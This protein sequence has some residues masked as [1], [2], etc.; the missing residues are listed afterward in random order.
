MD[1]RI[2]NVNGAGSEMLLE[3]LELAFKQ[4]GKNTKCKAWAI[5]KNHGLIL[6]WYKS[7]RPSECAFPSA[8]NAAG[9]LPFVMAWLQSDEAKTINLTGWD[10]DAD[11]DGSNSSGWRVYCG[12]WGHVGEYSNAICAITPAMMWHGK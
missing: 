10:A 12:D 6:L 4:E 8:L 5:N 11:H 3:T 7:D 1:N 9:C 2:F